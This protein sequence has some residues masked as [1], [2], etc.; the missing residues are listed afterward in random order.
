MFHREISNA[1]RI[2]LESYRSN[3]AL[4]ILDLGCGDGSMTLPLLNAD[5]I[6]SYVGCDL[7]K[8]ALD[9]AEK[10]IKTLS[11][12]AQLVCDD[13]RVSYQCARASL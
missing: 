12:A 4:R 11:I 7:S 5:R 3:E 2:A 9:I 10:Q 6:S 1:V 8:P 13:M